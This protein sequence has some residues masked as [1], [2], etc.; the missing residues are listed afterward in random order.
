MN[1]G[2]IKDQQVNISPNLAL[3]SDEVG[4]WQ[5]EQAEKNAKFSPLID[6]QSVYRALLTGITYDEIITGEPDRCPAVMDIFQKRPSVIVHV[7][8]VQRDPDFSS[9]KRHAASR[10][11]A[12]CEFAELALEQESKFYDQTK[13]PQLKARFADG[14]VLIRYVLSRLDNFINP[15]SDEPSAQEIED[16]TG[17]DI[18]PDVYLEASKLINDELTSPAGRRLHELAKQIGDLEALIESNKDALF[19]QAALS[20][21]PRHKAVVGLE[22]ITETWDYFRPVHDNSSS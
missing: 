1:E 13:F 22:T 11:E 5:N 12:M 7:A 4:E 16:M 10:Y 20:F 2:R 3:G 19:N 21:S 17:I 15:P 18:P 8:Q 9:L 6:H 14:F